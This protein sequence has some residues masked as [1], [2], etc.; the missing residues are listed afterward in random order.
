MT[1]PTPFVPFNP[2]LPFTLLLL[3]R[4]HPPLPLRR[5]LL[6]PFSLQLPRVLLRM[7]PPPFLNS[8][9]LALLLS[10]LSLVPFPRD[11]LVVST[12]AVIGEIDV[13]P[14]F[15]RMGGAREYLFGKAP[16][17]GHQ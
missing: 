2:S 12:V 9:L 5:L 7:C 13:T 6:F 17:R 16:L 1:S 14:I 4:L 10:P 8:G 3:L 15:P 11:P